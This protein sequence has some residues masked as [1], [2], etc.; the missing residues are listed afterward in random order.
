MTNSIRS[1]KRKVIMSGVL[2]EVLECG[3]IILRTTTVG[4]ELDAEPLR[5]CW[6]CRLGKPKDAPLEAPQ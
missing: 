4:H 1:P 5:R 3:H 2:S 6:K